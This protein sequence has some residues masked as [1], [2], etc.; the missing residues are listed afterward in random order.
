MMVRFHC[1]NPDCGRLLQVPEN[2]H[3]KKVQCPAC[4]HIQTAPGPP[5]ETAIVAEPA[6]EMLEVVP[7]DE[8]PRRR[9][10]RR[11][12]LHCP[13]C[14]AAVEPEDAACPECGRRLDLDR[15]EAEVDELQ[16]ERGRNQLLSFVFGLPGI[17]LAIG[18]AFVGDLPRSLLL[19][20]GGLLLWVGIFFGVAHKRDNLLW[21]LLGV[22]GCIGLLVLAILPDEKGQRLGRLRRYIRE[23]PHAD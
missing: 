12:E 10:R 15:I 11:V 17:G 8:P 6:D 14:L 22:L 4:G 3:G 13:Y 19:T 1:A 9:R 2:G 16:Q 23:H 5:Q 18:S 21:A 7:A 20:G